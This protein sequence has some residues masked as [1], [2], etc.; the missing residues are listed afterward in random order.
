MILLEILTNIC[1]YTDFGRAEEIAWPQV[2]RN[3]KKT[4]F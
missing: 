4:E 1:F 2:E 3:R